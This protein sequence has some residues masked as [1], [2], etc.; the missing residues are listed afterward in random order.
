V[1]KGEIMDKKNY[2]TYEEQFKD[3]LNN[4]EIGR[5]KNPNLREIRWKYW[6]LRH[7]AFINEEK[8]PDQELGK[9]TDEI[10]KAEQKELNAFKLKMQDFKE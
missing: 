5:I 10:N 3:I 2:L 6:E 7:K 8:I 1:G 4:E 9:V